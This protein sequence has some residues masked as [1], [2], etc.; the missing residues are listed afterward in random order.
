MEIDKTLMVDFDSRGYANQKYRLE[1]FKRE[2]SDV[3]KIIVHCTATDSPAWDNPEACINY[4][5]SP[6]HISRSGCPT[7]TYH[8]YVNKKGEAFQLVSMNIKT[9]NCAGQN[10]DSVAV[11]INH[12]GI[13]NNVTQEQFNSLAETI[14]Y[15]FDKLDWD[16]SEESVRDRLYFH[17]DF[18]NLKTCPGKIDKNEL[19]FSV[20]EK[21]KDYGDNV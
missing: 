6:N 1:N 4:D 8:F 3:E 20:I 21:L 10:S 16:Y 2:L 17:R 13:K 14:C 11:C 12:G 7:A 9:W 15:I 5:L 18:T 19:I